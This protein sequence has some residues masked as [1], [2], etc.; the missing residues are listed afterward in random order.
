MG[1]AAA[2]GE[3]GAWTFL[4]GGGVGEL[5]WPRATPVPEKKKKPRESRIRAALQ[6]PGI[7]IRTLPGTA[8]VDPARVTGPCFCSESIV[9]FHLSEVIQ[10]RQQESHGRNENPGLQFPFSNLGEPMQEKRPFPAVAI[11]WQET[12]NTR[13]AMQPL[14][15]IAHSR[16]KKRAS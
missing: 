10:Q 5:V 1:G 9:K 6:F 7:R 15:N 13:F 8:A 11:D 2:A 16:T 4:A 14:L 12:K 3:G